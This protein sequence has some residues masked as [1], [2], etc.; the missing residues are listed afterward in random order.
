LPQQYIGIYTTDFKIKD[1]TDELGAV[2]LFTKSGRHG[3]GIYAHVA[4]DK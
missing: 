2:G 4:M 3:G 1:W